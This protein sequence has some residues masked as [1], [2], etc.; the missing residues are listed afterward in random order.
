MLV[1]QLIF[2]AKIDIFQLP[3]KIKRALHIAGPRGCEWNDGIGPPANIASN[4]D[5]RKD[6]RGWYRSRHCPGP[7][8]SGLRTLLKR[9]GRSGPPRVLEETAAAG[10]RDNCY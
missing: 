2:F 6:L 8:I 7:N 5:R 1:H 9:R 10:G 3:D 4:L